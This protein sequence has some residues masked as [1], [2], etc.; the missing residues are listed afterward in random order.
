MKQPPPHPP[1][2]PRADPL[3]DKKMLALKLLNEGFTVAQVME[4]TGLSE[5]TV[6]TLRKDGIRPLKDSGSEGDRNLTPEQELTLMSLVLDG[7]VW[8]WLRLSHEVDIA[9]RWSPSPRGFQNYLLRWGLDPVDKRAPETDAWWKANRGKY[10]LRT[11][12]VLRMN[13]PT[14]LRQEVLGPVEEFMGWNPAGPVHRMYSCRFEQKPGNG[15]LA[16]WMVTI[17]PD[18]QDAEFVAFS[19]FAWH[20]A[21]SPVGKKTIVLVR[22][23]APDDAFHE[24]LTDDLAEAFKRDTGRALIVVPTRRQLGLD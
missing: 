8:D 16:C 22:G 21:Q 17:E 1:K 5:G 12:L 11:H 9:A 13:P 3:L 4:R 2:E 14:E 19:G 6:R 20:M 24:E 7:E 18:E 23:S 10:D 15:E